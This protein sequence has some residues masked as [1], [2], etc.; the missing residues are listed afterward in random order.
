M[1][2]ILI[3]GLLVGMM[4]GM[5]GSAAL[6]VLALDSVDSLAQGLLYILV[7]GL[8]PVLGM[9]VLAFA[10]S[11]PLCWSANTLTWAHNGLTALLSPVT[12]ILGLFVLHD[13]GPALLAPAVAA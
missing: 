6:I 9:T 2:S 12:V 4:H 3:L 7:F 1:A 13:T 10:I 5:A 8:G 11:L